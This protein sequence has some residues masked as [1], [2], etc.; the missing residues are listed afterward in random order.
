MAIN[1]EQGRR[2]TLAALVG[3]V[4]L[5]LATTADGDTDDTLARQVAE[6]ERR[7]DQLEQD[8]GRTT[9]DKRSVAD[10]L[11]ALERAQRELEK[12][13]ERAAGLALPDNVRDL[14]RQTERV[15]REQER[16]EDAVQRVT[17]DLRD[18]SSLG[19]QMR[20]NTSRIRD[21]QR[22]VDRL[23][24]DVDALERQVDRLEREI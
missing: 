4:I 21:L 13:F 18:A 9:P 16:I 8:Y 10:R 5:T 14:E 11:R 12:S 17:R 24:R 22:E 6:L 1:A 15:R 23:Q 2:L 19:S 20:E 7:V 3:A